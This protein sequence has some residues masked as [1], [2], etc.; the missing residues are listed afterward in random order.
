MVT[1]G[2]SRRSSRWPIGAALARSASSTAACGKSTGMSLAAMA[3]RLTVRGSL[4]GPMRSSTRA[5]RDSAPP[6]PRSRRCRPARA[7]FLSAGRTSKLCRSL[8]SVGVTR[9]MPWPPV[10]LFVEAEDLLRPAAQAADDARLVGVLPRRLRLASTRSPTAGAGPLRVDCGA[11]SM[12][13][14]G[15]SFSSSCLRGTAIRWPSLS[16]RTISS[17]VTSESAA[18][19]R[20]VLARSAAI[21]PVSRRSRSSAF[22]SMRWSPL[23]PKARAISRL[24]IGVALSR[25]KASSSSRVGTLPLAIG[26]S[27]GRG[28]GLGLGGLALGRGFLLGSF[29]FLFCVVGRRADFGRAIGLGNAFGFRLGAAFLARAGFLPPPLAA[30]SAS[31]ETA[32]SSVSSSGLRSR[33]T[34]ALM[35]PCF[36]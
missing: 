15:P 24:P 4:I 21:S 30:R 3:I 25:M 6:S 2:V 11:I 33:G 19:S 27:A 36:T 35:P 12:R 34:V 7:P 1:S 28:V 29:R 20:K 32:W 23:R 13:G 17:T 8:R 5:R 26:S 16:T 9:P 22:S 18:G 14:A 10:R 31:S